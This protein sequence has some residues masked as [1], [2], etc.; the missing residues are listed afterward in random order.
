M[1]YKMTAALALAAAL[2]M[3]FAAQPERK[4]AQVRVVEQEKYACVNCFFGGADYF[5]CFET[6][7]QILVAHDKVPT[8]NW[9]DGDKNYLGRVHGAWKFPSAAGD[10]IKIEYDDKHL[11]IPRGDGKEIRMDREVSHDP[12]TNARCRG[13]VKKA[14]GD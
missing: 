13:A 5:F 3:L 12:F 9:T 8:M 14:S 2:P 1:I 4:D 10:S 11:W 7:G 6:G